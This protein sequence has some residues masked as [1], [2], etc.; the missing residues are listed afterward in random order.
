MLLTQVSYFY[1]KYVE[2]V[3]FPAVDSYSFCRKI[4]LDFFYLDIYT[5]QCFNFLE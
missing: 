4:K 1:D 5:L 3:Y 2:Y